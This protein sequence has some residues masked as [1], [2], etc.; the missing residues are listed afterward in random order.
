MISTQCLE[1]K[2]Y[3]GLARCD[4][5]GDEQIPQEIMEGSH[6]HAE[7]YPG[8]HGIR[9]ERDEELDSAVAARLK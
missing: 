6:D 1:C 4:A 5:F 8:D 2:H 7:P 3:R 9:F